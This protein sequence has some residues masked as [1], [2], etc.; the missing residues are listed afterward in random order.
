MRQPAS[1]APTAITFHL[2]P[3]LLSHSLND[4]FQ[5][6]PGVWVLLIML[7]FSF[8]STSDLQPEQPNIPRLLLKLA[9]CIVRVARGGGGRQL[10]GGI[11]TLIKKKKWL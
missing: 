6:A 4:S 1:S 2:P 5:P 3:F 7:H 10:L 11:F 8:K 9:I